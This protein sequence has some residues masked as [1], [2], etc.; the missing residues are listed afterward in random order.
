MRIAF[1]VPATTEIG[2]GASTYNREM[3]AAL[4]ATGHS[5]ETVPLPGRFPLAD[6]IA[7]A[8]LD[9]AWQKLPPDAVPVIDG[10]VLSAFDR[11]RLT[12]RPCVG[13]IHHPTPLET[14]HSA[15][16]RDRLR[17]TECDLLPLLTKIVVTGAST[18]ARLTAEFGV[19][20]ARIRVIAP[21]TPVAPRSHGSGG[22]PCE[23][24]SIGSLVPRKAHDVLIR[25]VAALFDLDWRLTIVGG[26]S[27]DASHAAAL[28]SL[29]AE[30]GVA[31]RVTFAGEVDEAGLAAL[32]ART[33]VFALATHHEVTA[34]AVAEALRRGVPVAVT[35]GAAASSLVTPECGVV[36]PPGD[37]VQ[38]SKALRRLIFDRPLR[39]AM[40][41]AA[42]TIG[43]ALPDW[44]TQALAFAEAIAG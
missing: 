4:E 2:S 30:L 26:A 32:W 15:E 43:R 44:Q 37:V 29:V 12:A 39:A 34:M 33:D 11:S 18:G 31:D 3:A 16:D 28:A 42:W 6:D 5:I 13:L 17:A 19:D 27:R 40:A 21:G 22:G 36:C 35:E 14:G 1:I 38:L 24:L 20:A 7:K 23:I 41:D 10:F 8:A 9:A 25:A